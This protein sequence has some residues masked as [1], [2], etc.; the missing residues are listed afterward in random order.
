M[1]VNKR[2]ETQCVCF[3]DYDENKGKKDHVWLDEK[4]ER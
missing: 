4:R 1:F 3:G 2:N